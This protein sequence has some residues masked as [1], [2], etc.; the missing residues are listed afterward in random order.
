MAKK[1]R[2]PF[3]L[4]TDADGAPWSFGTGNFAG[5]QV[6]DEIDLDRRAGVTGNPPN[7]FDVGGR[8]YTFTI[9]QGP[10]SYRNRHGNLPVGGIY[11]TG[12]VVR[13]DAITTIPG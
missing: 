3:P 6:G 2:R 13:I 4:P 1:P 9:L 11:D 7:P 10:R 5:I 8:R 12:W